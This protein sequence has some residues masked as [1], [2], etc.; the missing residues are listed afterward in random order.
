MG[1]PTNK[2]IDYAIILRNQLGYDPNDYDFD[3]MTFKQMQDLLPKQ[4]SKSLDKMSG[5]LSQKFS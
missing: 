3:N 1:R 4:T 5:S 2:M